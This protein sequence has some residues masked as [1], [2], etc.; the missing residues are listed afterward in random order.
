MEYALIAMQHVASNKGRVVSAKEIA[1]H[2]GIS[3]EF[4]SKALQILV[5]GKFIVSQ[6]GVSGGYILASDPHQM[7]VGAI[8]EAVD[9]KQAIVECCG[10]G[11]GQCEMHHRC[12]IKSPMAIIQQRIDSVL[13]SMTV[14]QLAG[15]AA[16]VVIGNYDILASRAANSSG[17]GSE[18]SAKSVLQTPS[19]VA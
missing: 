6:Q 1:E 17:I 15:D 7:T 18:T 4:L 2:Y 14:A 11:G 19:R 16:L 10:A 13:N 5:R 12:P 9:G 3:F 8:I